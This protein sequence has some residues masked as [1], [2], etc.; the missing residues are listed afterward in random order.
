MRKTLWQMDRL[1]GHFDKH[2][3][4]KGVPNYHQMWYSIPDIYYRFDIVKKL[5]I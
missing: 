3:Y 2:T 4:P 1:C 5:S